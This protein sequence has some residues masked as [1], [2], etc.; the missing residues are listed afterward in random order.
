MN[1][2][3]F[4]KLAPRQQLNDLMHKFAQITGGNY[5]A[6]W[7]ELDRRWKAIHGSALSWLRWKHNRD[8]QTT[9]TIPAYLEA[10]GK[11]DQAI[12]IAKAMKEEL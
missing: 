1:E 11:L 3:Y 10:T 4:N 7:K 2:D 12:T 6:G 9:L 5:G 8:K